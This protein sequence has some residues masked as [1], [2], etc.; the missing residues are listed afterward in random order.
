[1]NWRAIV[2]GTVALGIALAGPADAQKK[3]LAMG[4][5]ATASSHFAYCVGQ[6]KA[7][8]SVVPDVDVTVVETGATVDNLKRMLK[9]TVDYGLMTS[10][11]AYLAHRGEAIWKD[12][13]FPDVRNLWFYTVSAI[14]I[15]VREETG[16]KSVEDLT[17]KKF[18]PGFRGAATEKMTEATLTHLG[19]K[20]DWVR[21][22]A[23]DL[24]DA[25]KDK[26]IVGYAKAAD[27]FRLDASMMD[28]AA[29]NPIRVLPFSDDQVKKVKE[30]FPYYPWLR[31][32]AGSVKGMGE[33]WAQGVVVGFAAP[34]SLPNDVAYKLVK[35]VMEDKEHQKAAFKGLAEDMVKV[36]LELSLSPLHA[37]AIK[38]YREK[39][40][41]IPDH[42]VPAEAR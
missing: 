34:K 29:T 6:A 26:R 25:I 17:G 38:Y 36:T 20:A 18:S 33:F 37:G 9:G 41:R 1:M 12:T 27:G 40:L 28:I 32:P 4:C 24:V 13:P 21:G 8:N 31:V 3:R 22:G 14:Y 16:I 5:T 23:S 39:G 7:I 2:V 30:K 42:L 19:I 11:Q 35:A 10:D 15:S